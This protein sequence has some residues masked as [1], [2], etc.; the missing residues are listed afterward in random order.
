[1]SCP[2]LGVVDIPAQWDGRDVKRCFGSRAME[3]QQ[4]SRWCWVCFWGNGRRLSGCA[5][6]MII[7]LQKYFFLTGEEDSTICEIVWVEVL[8]Q[9]SWGRLCVLLGVYHTLVWNRIM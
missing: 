5:I 9:L 3:Y 4:G 2:S 6:L 7:C 8:S 1:M